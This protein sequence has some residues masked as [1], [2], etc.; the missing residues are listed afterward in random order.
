M[1]TVMASQ[2]ATLKPTAAQKPTRVTMESVSQQT[3]G[4][5]CAKSNHHAEVRA[6]SGHR[7]LSRDLYRLHPRTCE[8]HRMSCPVGVI[9]PPP[10]SVPAEDLMS[11][12]KL[13]EYVQ[14]DLEFFWKWC[15]TP[16]D[17]LHRCGLLV[18]LFDYSGRTKKEQKI[19][20][21]VKRLDSELRALQV[22]PSDSIQF[23]ERVSY[24]AFV[25]SRRLVSAI[26]RCTEVRSPWERKRASLSWHKAAAAGLPPPHGGEVETILGPR[27]PAATP[28][29]PVVEAHECPPPHKC[30]LCTSAPLALW[31]ISVIDAQDAVADCTTKVNNA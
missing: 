27:R 5:L 13:E 30:G 29:T 19:V 21:K 10:A 2:V 16:L 25:Q 26:A 7:R 20:G 9:A 15:P 22:V 4:E 14:K 23:N 18:K 8:D 1:L 12:M 28:G 31:V 24:E 11:P 3:L 6:M 17:G